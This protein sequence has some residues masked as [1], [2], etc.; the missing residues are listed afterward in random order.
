MKRFLMG[1][2]LALA[3]LATVLLSNLPVVLSSAT[4]PLPIVSP[5][6][7]TTTVEPTVVAAAPAEAP[8]VE[9]TAVPVAPDVVAPA[10]LALEP[11]SLA[12][13]RA[14]C[15][16]YASELAAYGLDIEDLV[17]WT[18]FGLGRFVEA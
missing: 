18:A 3:L 12:A 10:Y 15:A 13:H 1:P 9:V 7:A 14:A 2:L 4:R 16:G 5:V 11:C 8:V 6:A 17:P